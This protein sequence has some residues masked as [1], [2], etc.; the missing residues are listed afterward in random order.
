[1][2]KYQYWKVLDITDIANAANPS[3]LR[4]GYLVLDYNR[5]HTGV[6]S[7][8]RLW[9]SCYLLLATTVL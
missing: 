9:L 2:Y 7:V 6:F 4:N 8:G 5:F 1:M 3:F